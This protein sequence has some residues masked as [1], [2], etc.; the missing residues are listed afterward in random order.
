MVRPLTASLHS[1]EFPRTE[2]PSGRKAARPASLLEA[3]R[4]GERRRQ[5]RRF[6]IADHIRVMGEAR[7]EDVWFS[8]GTSIFSRRTISPENRRRRLST[9]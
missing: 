8:R 9:R 5:G 1:R 6:E 4:A 7:I 2:K 3:D